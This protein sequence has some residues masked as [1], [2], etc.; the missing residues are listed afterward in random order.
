MTDTGLKDGQLLLLKEMFGVELHPDITH[1]PPGK[2]GVF[3][4]RPEVETS[5]KGGFI[6]EKLYRDGKEV[7]SNHPSVQKRHKALLSR[8][9]GKVFIS[10]LG[11]GETLFQV[12]QR[13]EVSLVA[14]IES[15]QGVIDL[16]L[17]AIQGLP[18]D[19]QAK[20]EYDQANI[21]S[22]KLDAGEH[23]DFIYHAIWSTPE[24]QDPKHVKILEKRF[25]S[26]CDWHGCV[27]QNSDGRGGPGRGG[28]R[29]KGKKVGPFKP[30]EQQRSVKKGLRFTP[31]EYAVVQ[32]A[33]ELSG[34][35]EASIMQSGTVDKA[36]SI[37]QMFIAK[38]PDLSSLLKG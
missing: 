28:G 35:S 3:E 12:V 21:F 18:E 15:E 22:Y 24:E 10:G 14:V 17:P 6:Y 31:I 30:P 7:A 13:P 32:K 2:S 8:A 37:I 9:K 34:L 1:V 11:L 33:A 29:K 23:F 16:V 38:D 4:V 26:F 27:F 20:V 25:R 5:G 19:I 36:K